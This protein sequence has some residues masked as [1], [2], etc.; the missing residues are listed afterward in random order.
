MLG[1]DLTLRRVRRATG[2]AQEIRDAE[3]PEDLA[4]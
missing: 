3:H 4:W 2:E 1:A